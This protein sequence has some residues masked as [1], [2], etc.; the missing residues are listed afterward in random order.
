[1]LTLPT[2]ASIS[3]ARLLL[4]RDDVELS[5]KDREG[6]TAFDLYNL[7][8]EGGLPDPH[9]SSRS[10]LYTWGTNRN[11]VLGNTHGD[12]RQLPERISIKRCNGEHVQ[13]AERFKYLNVSR[14]FMS[15][16][17]TGIITE[18][19]TDNVRFCGFGNG[20]R[21]GRSV[22]TQYAFE[23]P[24]SLLD[25]KAVVMALAQ[26][27]TLLLDSDGHV[28]SFGFNKY[29]QLGYAVDTPTSQHAKF[30]N[31]SD[32]FQITPKRIVGAL[33]KEVMDGV[34]AGK[35]ASACWK[36]DTLYTWGTNEGH[37]GG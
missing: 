10:E 19:D 32:P 18:E 6:Y 27:H 17:H 13:D 2:G 24:S 36:N 21:L 35:T 4:A 31:S 34:A 14:V 25:V 30:T 23:T 22:H 20:G 7:T 33:K 37:L 16:L 5:I 9:H 1:M 26:D 28:Y 11:Y 3:F 29:Q 8:I 15:K 12:D